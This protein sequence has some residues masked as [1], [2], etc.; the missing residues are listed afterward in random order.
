MLTRDHAIED[1]ARVPIASDLRRVV[2]ERAKI[3]TF[4]MS[5][6]HE[7]AHLQ[8]GSACEPRH[9]YTRGP[10]LTR[11]LVRVD[12]STIERV[13]GRSHEVVIGP[14]PVKPIK[15]KLSIERPKERPKHQKKPCG[16]H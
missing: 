13:I 7:A 14:P 2:C 12:S 4:A 16:R 5:C 15:S 1:I 9:A 6:L 11:G 8:N 10:V 3:S